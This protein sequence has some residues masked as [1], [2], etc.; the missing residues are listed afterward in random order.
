MD[1]SKYIKELL[2]LHECVILPDFGGFIANYRS[3]EIDHSQKTLLPPSKYLSFNGNLTHNDG[4]LIS[5]LSKKKGIGYVDSKRI[6]TNFINETKSRLR[7]GKKVYLEGIGYFIFDDQNI[8]QF[9]PDIST[10]FL[11]DSFGLSPFHFQSIEDYDLNKKILIKTNDKDTADKL[12]RKRRLQRVL[13][14]VPL[15]IALALIPFKAPDPANIQ[16]ETTSFNPVNN[17]EESFRSNKTSLDIT[18][19]E[20]SDDQQ[21]EKKETMLNQ[22]TG[23]DN[24]SEKS[25]KE[26]NKFYLIN[27]S[28]RIYNNA[29][30]LKNQL[31]NEGY[32]AE[33]L[34]AE[35]NMFRV[36]MRA[37]PTRDEALLELN[38]I[39]AEKG[40]DAVWLLCI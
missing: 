20:N 37:F 25:K 28:F 1:L 5:F 18:L 22:E 36:A 31:I 8:L 33:I 39:R 34:N 23:S 9:E 29:V 12:L 13:V 4:L 11:I 24:I 27:G 19:P 7:K 21:L 16:H 2:F 14:G 3:A 40:K 38:R 17:D 10:N 30:Y 32:E 6:V 35:N 26:L 15:L